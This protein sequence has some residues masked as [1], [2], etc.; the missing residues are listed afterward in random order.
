LSPNSVGC[1]S[2]R[3]GVPGEFNKSS[4][5]SYSS[6]TARAFGSSCPRSPSSHT[7]STQADA[8]IWFSSHGFTGIS[9]KHRLV[10]TWDFTGFINVSEIGGAHASATL[11]LDGTYLCDNG[12]PNGGGC[13][14]FPNGGGA[15]VGGWSISSTVPYYG[16]RCNSSVNTTINF[17]ASVYLNTSLNGS[18][19]YSFFVSFYDLS[20]VS[21]SG[22]GAQATSK[23]WLAAPYGGARLV[24]LTVY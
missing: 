22:K 12:V 24:A 4:G 17:T 23:V 21:A 3:Y 8:I 19:S 11:G 16:C 14:N 7:S 6:F 1:T 9:G 5:E 20:T 18:R 2:V 15:A 10:V 13:T